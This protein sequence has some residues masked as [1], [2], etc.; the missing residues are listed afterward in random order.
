M[1]PR[2]KKLR[3]SFDPVGIDA[4]LV[5]KDINISYLT[6][7]PAS[8]SWLLVCRKNVFYLTDFR[9]VLEA[10]KGL[11]GVAV[12]QYQKSIYEAFAQITRR[13]GVRRVGIDAR[14]LSLFQF[15]SLKKKSP[16]SLSLVRTD[17]LVERLRELK[18]SQE[19]KKILQ[20]LAVHKQMHLFLKKIL[21]S[22]LS[23][24]EIL[25]RLEEF[26][27][28]K[29][30]KFSFDPI[31]AGG[32]NSCYP[33]AK[34]TRRKIRRDDVVLVD[35]GIDQNG[36]KSDLTRMFFLGRIP[37]L[38]RETDAVVAAAQRKAI[39]K[40]APGVP[41]SQIDQAARNYLAEHKL[42]QYFGHAL[43]HGVGL[44]IH[45]NPRLSADNSSILREGMV[46]TVE[47]AVYIP[48]Q[49]GIRIEDMVLVTKKGCEILSD[50][51]H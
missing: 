38:V 5:T 21:K 40:I 8:E 32:T 16:S 9:Y 34:V 23:E 48:R 37:R 13:L 26:I 18:E 1:N 44:E 43:G 22:G 2:V 45:E 39:E 30:V 46:I 31:V 20:S 12:I 42:A 3:L 25:M 15:E 19:V 10:K 33:H 24:N 36:Y 51:I 50:D 47:P 27:R 4:F 41:I 14:H 35:V 11:K 28:M 17:Q 29:G 6:G 7:F 49:F